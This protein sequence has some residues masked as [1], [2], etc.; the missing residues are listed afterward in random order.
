M[1]T[2][3]LYCIEQPAQLRPILPHQHQELT[4]LLGALFKEQGDFP[5]ARRYL[6]AVVQQRR[7]RLGPAATTTAL[8]NLATLLHEQGDLAAARQIFERALTLREQMLGPEHP[9]TAVLIINLG[10]LLADLG[11]LKGARAY[12]ERAQAIHERSF[13]PDHP[14]ITASLSSIGRLAYVEGDL[15]AAQRFFEQTLAISRRIYGVHHPDTAAALHN[16]S[17]TRA[18]A[19]DYTA[20]QQL[21]QIGSCSEN[22]E[23]VSPHLERRQARVH[24]R[25]ADVGRDRQGQH[26]DSVQFDP[27]ILNLLAGAGRAE[28][29]LLAHRLMVG[30][31]AVGRPAQRELLRALVGRLAKD[32]ADA[33]DGLGLVE[34]QAD[35]LR[36]GRSGAPTPAG[37]GAEC[38]LDRMRRVF[39][40]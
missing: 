8:N 4:R 36:P 29:V 1:L 28:G 19:G 27:V 15:D 10:D 5:A 35:R 21:L 37:R 14:R 16:V 38:R 23:L 3:V 33:P 30:L 9:D 39:R 24:R 34:D 6:Q 13:P 26:G 22:C 20:A 31:P 32:K 12:L 25:A 18:A 17:L 11:D 7:A 2:H 40:G